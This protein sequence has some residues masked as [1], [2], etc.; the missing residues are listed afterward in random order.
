MLTEAA[1]GVLG[2]DAAVPTEQ[3]LGGEDFG[4]YLESVPGAYGRLGTRTPGSTHLADIHQGTFDVDETAIGTGVR[5]L[6]ATAL[7]ALWEGRRPSA[8]S[9]EP[10]LALNLDN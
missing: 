9:T 5:F 8:A 10:L 6:A 3:S 1:E 2:E 7:T 4:W